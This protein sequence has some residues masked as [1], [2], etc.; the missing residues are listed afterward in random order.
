M[1]SSLSE[2]LQNLPHEAKSVPHG[3]S[4]AVVHSNLLLTKTIN[5]QS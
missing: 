4:G 1:N 3:L 2:A 5:S